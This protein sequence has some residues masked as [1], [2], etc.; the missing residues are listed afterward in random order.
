MGL[1]NCLP[2]SASGYIQSRHFDTNLNVGTVVDD[3]LVGL[4]GL[5]LGTVERSETP[6]LG[7][8]DLLSSREL[9]SGT[10]E[11]LHDDGL[12]AVSASDGHDD[13]TAV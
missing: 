1:R 3:L 6:L 5:V 13:L 11:G 7:N 12:V 8:D 2:T 9:V 4:E 10:S